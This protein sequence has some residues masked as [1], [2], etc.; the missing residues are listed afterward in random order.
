MFFTEKSMAQKHRCI[1]CIPEYESEMFRGAECAVGGGRRARV[2]HAAHADAVVV[3]WART[4][5]GTRAGT[6]TSACGGRAYAAP[7]PATPSPQVSEHRSYKP[8]W[9]LE[10]ALQNY[11]LKITL[12]F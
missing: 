4:P 10:C 9:L 2:V 8:D 1:V 6:S 3:Q 7:A 5:R 11:E 12:I